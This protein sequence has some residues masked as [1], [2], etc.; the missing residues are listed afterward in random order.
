MAKKNPKRRVLWLTM[1][2]RYKLVLEPNRKD[3]SFAE[4]ERSVKALARAGH[5]D[6]GDGWRLEVKDVRLLEIAAKDSRKP[7]VR[8]RS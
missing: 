2:V 5:A 3:C 8:D 6:G 7:K 1:G 4:I